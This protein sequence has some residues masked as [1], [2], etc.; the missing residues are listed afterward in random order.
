M[1]FNAFSLSAAILTSEYDCVE[2][3]WGGGWM[4]GWG[5]G[6]GLGLGSGEAVGEGGCQTLQLAMVRNRS[7]L[8]SDTQYAQ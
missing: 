5:Q 3:G 7:L 8:R 4:G 2:W 1:R 6:V